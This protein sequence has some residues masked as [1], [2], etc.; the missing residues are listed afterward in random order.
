MKGESKTAAFKLSSCFKYI[1]EVTAPIDL[2]HKPIVV[3]AGLFCKY[4]TTYAKSS[5]SYQ[6][7]DMY[8][9]S[10]FPHPVKSNVMRDI[11]YLISSPKYSIPY[12]LLLLFPCRYTTQGYL[13]KSRGMKCDA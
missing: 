4:S 12:V 9:P 1:K 2:P 8:Y 6:P 3:T 7:R 5:H 10:E 11:P 13:Y